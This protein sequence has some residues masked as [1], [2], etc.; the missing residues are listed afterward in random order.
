[1]K[2]S[3]VCLKGLFY[4]VLLLL[5]LVMFPA[6]TSFLASGPFGHEVLPT[7]PLSLDSEE[8]QLPFVPETSLYVHYNDTTSSWYSED[9]SFFGQAGLMQAFYIPLSP[10]QQLLLSAASSGWYGKASF[11]RKEKT[12]TLNELFPGDY[13]FYGVSSQGSIIY[14]IGSKTGFRIGLSSLISWEEGDYA[15]LRMLLEQIPGTFVYES[16]YNLSPTPWSHSHI[17]E[18]GLDFEIAENTRMLLILDAGIG[19]PELSAE[20]DNS[21]P[22][23]GSTVLIRHKKVSL[24]GSYRTMSFLNHSVNAGLIVHLF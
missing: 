20:D 16:Y 6:C 19:Y 1:M 8:P 7:A 3:R 13:D 21:V 9:T 4:S 2:L 15:K 22:L 12:E 23:S 17:A 14:R 11:D 18:I 10:K 5:T 24:Y